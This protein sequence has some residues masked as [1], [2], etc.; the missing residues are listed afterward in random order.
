MPS[1]AR[2]FFPLRVCGVA[3]EA[4]ASVLTFE[5]PQRLRSAFRYQSG[6]YLTL[7]ASVGGEQL[8]RQYA[9]CSAPHEAP[10]QVAIKHGQ[11]AMA[12]WIQHRLAPGSEL[13]VAPPAGAFTVAAE[14]ARRRHYLGVCIGSGVTALYSLLKHLLHSEPRSRFTLLIGEQDHASTLFLPALAELRRRLGERLRCVLVFSCARP[15][16][17]AGLPLYH[18]RLDQDTLARICA[19]EVDL[20]SVDLALVVGSPAMMDELSGLLQR[21]GLPRQRIR[22]AG[23]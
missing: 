3:P 1:P 10:L 21:A 19:R 17:P 13:P 8:E 12:A 6:Q 18:G 2:L 11:G 15:G 14:P 20:D 5:V 16:A 23:D 22:T 4:G 7:R 9:I